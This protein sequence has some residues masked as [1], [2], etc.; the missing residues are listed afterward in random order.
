MDCSGQQPQRKHPI[1]LGRI[2]R[3]MAHYI[4]ILPAGQLLDQ[5]T[6]ISWTEN[7]LNDD[8]R[9][10]A[11]LV[12]GGGASYLRVIDV[13]TPEFFNPNLHQI[14]INTSSTQV[15]SSIGAGPDLTVQFEQNW[16]IGFKYDGT[17][18]V[19]NHEDFA[20]D[21]NEPYFF[22]TTDADAQATLLAIVNG[23]R[24]N[25]GAIFVLW[26]GAGVNPFGFSKFALG[27]SLAGYTSGMAV[28]ASK[29]VGAALGTE[30]IHQ[31]ALF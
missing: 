26:D 18:W 1:H 28:G 30:K 29:L 31:A 10:P 8:T 2:D 5:E 11:S 13:R 27:T 25:A 15:G 24:N 16:H 14:R 23:I 4:K 3:A 19:L 20:A 21:T 22:N 7:D 9:L 12:A 17:V 6:R